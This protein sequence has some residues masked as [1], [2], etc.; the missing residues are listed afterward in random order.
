MFN[1]ENLEISRFFMYLF[2]LLAFGCKPGSSK[3]NKGPKKDTS[4]HSSWM[5]ERNYLDFIMIQ[6]DFNFAKVSLYALITTLQWDT[7]N[8]K[9]T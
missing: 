4:E 6:M 7:S 9:K 8:E 2:S 5:L 1:T 3:E